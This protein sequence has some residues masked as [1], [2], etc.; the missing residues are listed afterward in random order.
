MARTL[1]EVNEQPSGDFDRAPLLARRE[2][3]SRLGRDFS[4]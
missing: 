3:A 4:R 1:L 2:A